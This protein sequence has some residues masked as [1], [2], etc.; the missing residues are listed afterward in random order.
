MSDELENWRPPYSIAHPALSEMTLQEL[1]EESYMYAVQA[2]RYETAMW[3]VLAHIRESKAWKAQNDSWEDFAREWL[4][5]VCNRAGKQMPF[6]VREIQTRLSNYTRLASVGA[7]PELVLGASSDAMAKLTRAIGDWDRDGKL[8]KMSDAARTGLERMYADME[9]DGDRIRAVAETVAAIPVHKDAIQF[10]EDNLIGL[11]SETTFEFTVSTG[12]D[13]V[14]LV[15]AVRST[16]NLA[17]GDCTEQRRFT[18]KGDESWP[19][20]V[21]DEMARR[22]R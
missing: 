1:L 17:N 2:G 20:E 14:P 16:W 21:V 22:L 8:V 19:D 9:T 4:Q 13:G 7:D 5:E 15:I 12:P 11:D 3:V 6:S 18:T 10:I